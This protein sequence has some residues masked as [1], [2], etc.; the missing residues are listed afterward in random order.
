MRRWLMMAVTV[1]V[2]LFWPPRVMAQYKIR[3]LLPNPAGDEVAQ[4]WILLEP[5]STPDASASASCY[6]EDLFGSAKQFQIAASNFVSDSTWTRFYRS[7]TGITLNNDSDGV[8][9]VCDQVEVDRTD[10]FEDLTDDQVWWR[11]TQNQWH[12]AAESEFAALLAAGTWVYSDESKNAETDTGVEESVVVGHNFEMTNLETTNLET[13]NLETDA[14]Q[15]EQH[16]GV[17]NEKAEALS[18]VDYSQLKAPC[19][20]S[21]FALLA[22]PS[23]SVSH[24]LIPKTDESPAYPTI[25]REAEIA[26]FLKWKNRALTG[27]LSLFLGGSCWV[28]AF[29]PSLWRW[30]NKQRY[31]C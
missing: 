2:F 23:A 11:D 24:D 31:L 19:L 25:D 4:E 29:G 7:Q 21:N 26:A 16:I 12:V 20:V 17:Q 18:A 6:M 1:V 3:A 9:L 27:S 13:T 8:R 14:I 30:Y 5:T 28:L 10:L 22:T 15:D